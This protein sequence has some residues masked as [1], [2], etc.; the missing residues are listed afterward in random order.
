MLIQLLATSL[1]K[2]ENEGRPTYLS[3]QVSLMGRSI[4]NVIKC[5]G[6]TKKRFQTNFK[7][8]SK[9]MISKEVL[10]FRG[11]WGVGVSHSRSYTIVTFSETGSRLCR[12]NKIINTS[13]ACFLI[14]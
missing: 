14:S 1:L 7:T 5:R 4:P 12:G 3:T 10:Q 9:N 8:E 2:T 11:K 6:G 13:K